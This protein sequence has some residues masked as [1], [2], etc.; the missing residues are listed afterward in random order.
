[1]TDRHIPVIVLEPDA[2]PAHELA[3]EPPEE[4]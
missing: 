3:H 2:E 1:M 4:G